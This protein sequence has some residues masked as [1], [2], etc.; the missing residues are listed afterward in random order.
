MTP[1][2][3][4]SRSPDPSASPSPDVCIIA[5]EFEMP[6]VAGRNLVVLPADETQIN[7]ERIDGSGH[8]CR[9]RAPGWR[10]G[11]VLNQASAALRSSRHS[12]RGAKTLRIPHRCADQL[13][14][15][16]RAVE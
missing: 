11:G 9:A 3:A 13:R 8:R 10:P 6:A 7:L 15:V 14:P 1:D 16:R 5:P 12:R 4:V 2:S